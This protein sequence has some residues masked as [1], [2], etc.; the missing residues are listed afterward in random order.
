MFDTIRSRAPLRISFAGG[1]TDV[2][3]YPEMKEGCV[4][5]TS[6]DR[7][8]YV[9]L[10]LTSKNKIIVK[11]QDYGL[12]ESFDSISDLI[13][14]GKLDLVTTTMKSL[15]VTNTS[16]ESIL[17][18]DAPPGSGLG[19]SSALIVSLI[20][21]LS[22]LGNFHFSHYDLAEKAF[23]IERQELG[24]EG[25]RQ[26]QYA[27]T[28]GGFNFFEFKKDHVEV[29]PLRIRKS[30]IN[31]LLASILIC[32]TT[33]TRLSS[34][35]LKRQSNSYLSGDKDVI[36]NLDLIKKSAY[37]MKHALLRGKIG[38]ISRLL[39]EGW[40]YKKKLDSGIS[41]PKI[42]KLYDVALQAGSYGGKLMGAG[43]GGHFLFICEPERREDVA[44]AMMKEGCKIHRINFDKEGLQVWEKKNDEVA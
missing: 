30:I 1:G 22:K 38:E 7:Y 3:P 15:G 42:D 26:D 31:E 25:G 12:F 17:H 28:F 18:V 14:N 20:G 21:A 29:T 35:I 44:R 32:D 10:N 8:A 2:S 9:T 13:K 37:D 39:H 23:Q 4:I 34:N 19:S 36:D 27:S 43:G 24:I 5:S 40:L 6:I 33:I 16:F 41:P 11:S